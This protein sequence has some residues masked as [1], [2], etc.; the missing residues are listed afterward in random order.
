[1]LLSITLAKINVINPTILDDNDLNSIIQERFTGV[2]IVE[3][4]EYAHIKVYQNSHYIHFLIKFPHIERV[5]K[6][7]TIYP[8]SHEH[9]ILHLGTNNVV[10]ECAKEILAVSNCERTTSSTICMELQNTTCVQQIHSGELAHCSTRHND[11]DPIN[12]IDE[13]II[14]INDITSIIKS[15]NSSTK[16]LNGTFLITFDG[17]VW[18]NG[19][20]YTNHNNTHGKHP[21]AAASPLIN[22]IG[23]QEI[24]SLPFL[25]KLNNNNLHY[26]GRLEGEVTK[27]PIKICCAALGSIIILY[28]IVKLRQH[29]VHRREQAHLQRA[30]ATIEEPEDGLHLREGGVNTQC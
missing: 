3:I 1:M 10:A 25:R 11:L 23:H 9:K 22:I 4:L 24:L 15:N 20:H 7:V 17:E 12:E 27:R 30:I 16:I 18:I 6:M 26:I 21:A 14:I 19:A 2:S 29:Q 5:C 28:A 13:G 8:V